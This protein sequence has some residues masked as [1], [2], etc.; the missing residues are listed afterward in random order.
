MQ[1]FG[2]A[3][4]RVEPLRAVWASSMRQ[5]VQPCVLRGAVSPAVVVGKQGCGWPNVMVRLVTLH[6]ADVA[7]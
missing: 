5:S 4:V 2:R 1:R 6:D 7:A 3:V